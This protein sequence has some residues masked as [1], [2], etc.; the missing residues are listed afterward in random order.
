MGDQMKGMSLAQVFDIAQHA[1]AKGISVQTAAKIM[2]LAEQRS[3]L[4]RFAIEMIDLIAAESKTV[5]RISS[6][7]KQ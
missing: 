1:Q 5:N 7:S 4:H 2:R 3:R 6:G